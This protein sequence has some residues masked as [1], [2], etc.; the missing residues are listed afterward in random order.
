[1]KSIYHDWIT[2][3]N[4]AAD[5]FTQC[6]AWTL[7]MNEAFPELRRVAGEVILSNGWTRH[8]W[9]L[10]DPDGS[11]VDPTASQ[12]SQDYFGKAVIVHYRE[13]DEDNRPTG[14][15]RNCGEHCYG[16]RTELCSESCEREYVAYVTATAAAWRF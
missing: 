8:H 16:G 12:F 1:V 5:P 3:K 7:E 9:W 6:G 4:D 14:K 10:V 2:H 13:I 11:I 15:C